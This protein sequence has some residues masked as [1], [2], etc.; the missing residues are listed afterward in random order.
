MSWLFILNATHVDHLFIGR[1]LLGVSG[2]GIFAVGPIF[3]AEIAEDRIRGTLG[4]FL[5]LFCNVGIV[6]GFIFAYYF[7]YNSTPI[8]MIVITVI[9]VFGM[10]CMAE[11]PL[12]LLSK[13]NIDKAKTALAF[14]RGVNATSSPLPESFVSD[15]QKYN[16]QM[17]AKDAASQVTTF[18][19]FTTKTSIKAIIISIFII[20]LPPLSGN[21]AFMSYTDQIFQ[22]AGS[23][24][25]SD[26]SSIIVALIQLVGSYLSTML[27]DKAGRKVSTQTYLRSD[28]IADCMF[29][30]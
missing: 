18:H 11:S 25:S 13:H 7:G 1:V 12:F 23:N 30:V 27:I 4:S 22:E 24:L 2:G 20:M 15:L 14:Y 5:S 3:V 16:E 6:F 19:D 29:L 26:I 21:I 28:K 10:V 8:F 9:F 17:R